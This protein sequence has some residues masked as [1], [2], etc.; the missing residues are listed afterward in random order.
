[1]SNIHYG[2]EE[3]LA[4][5][6]H[7]VLAIRLAV[8]QIYGQI[9]NTCGIAMWPLMAASVDKWKPLSLAVEYLKNI[10]KIADKYI[11]C[12]CLLFFF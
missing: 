1:M 2:S 9:S 7:D 12:F 6:R 8:H 5:L 10:T 3:Y 4:K 11:S